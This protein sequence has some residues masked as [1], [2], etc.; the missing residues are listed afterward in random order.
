MKLKEVAHLINGQ[1]RGDPELEIKGVN[2]LY[3][4]SRDQLAYLQPEVSRVELEKIKAAALILKVGMTFNYANEIYVDDPRIAFKTLLEYFYPRQRI[5]RDVSGLARIESGVNLGEGVGVGH[6]SWI[7][8]GSEIGAGT[9]IHCHVAI[10]PGVKIG[11]NCLIYSN[12]VIYSGTEIGSEV[13]IHSGAV[14]GADGF[15]Y[16]RNLQGEVEKIPQVGR[17]FI[18]DHCEIGANSCIDRAALEETRLEANVKLDNLVQVGHN[19]Q[20]GAN[21]T[22]SAQCGIGGSTKIGANVV[23]GGQVGV[24]DHITVADGVMAAGQCG[25]TSTIKEKGIVIAGMPAQEIRAWRKNAV[26]S[27]SL[28][29]IVERLRNLEKEIKGLQR[30]G[31]DES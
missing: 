12:V 29:K 1:L 19:V 8:S 9:E 11:K 21:T 25:I 4:A 7:G 15:G 22:I 6:F 16:L 2:S 13:I 26:I 24:A 10:Y 17:V 5:F 18:A 28:E 30:G 20:I 14:I 31:N 23:F 27:M 3:R